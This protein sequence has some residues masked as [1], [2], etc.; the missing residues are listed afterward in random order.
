MRRMTTWILALSLVIGVTAVFADTKLRVFEGE[1]GPVSDRNIANHPMRTSS[2]TESWYMMVHGG[3]DL[4]IFLHFGISN[5]EP[6]SRGNGAVEATI[7]HQGKVTF[8][9]DKTSRRHVSFS[10][11]KLDLTIGDHSLV[12]TD[13]GWRVKT[14]Q[15]GI[16]LDLLV[17][18][19]VAGIRPGRTVYPKGEFYQIDLVAPRA[20]AEGSL[21]LDGKRLE[22]KGNAYFDHSVQDYPPHRMADRLYSFRGYSEKDGI[23]FLLFETP[24]DLGGVSMPTLVL[25]RGDEVIVRTAAVEMT[26]AEIVRD[27]D[28]DYTYPTQWSFTAKDGDTEV[29]GTISLNRRVH[30][31]NA[32]DDF[33]AVERALIRTFIAN[34]M[35]YRHMGDYSFTVKGETPVTLSGSGIAE[36]VILRE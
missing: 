18:P 21:K 10:E 12:A 26:G 34:P 23:N 19:V 14:R 28:Y 31:Q 22:I 30:V 11:E 27:D 36:V 3:E 5:L 9:K 4:W 8:K 2:Y 24:D 35:L 20:V 33:N 32:A 25:M 7:L 1:W 17:K 15:D 29:E 13:E 16:E 6:F